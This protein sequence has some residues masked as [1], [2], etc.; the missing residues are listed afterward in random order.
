MFGLHHYNVI[1]IMLHVHACML[2][3]VWYFCVVA[4]SSVVNLQIINMWKYRQ[5]TF[6]FVPLIQG[7][8]IGFYAW[9]LVW[10]IYLIASSPCCTWKPL[11]DNTQHP[12]LQHRNSILKINL[13]NDFNM[14]ITG[15][16]SN[17]TLLLYKL[18]KWDVYQV[19]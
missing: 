19:L 12:K 13:G 5:S 10:C 11:K 14:F 2:L 16:I 17:V 6:V 1:N 4:R 3:C 18:Y 9:T 15:E 7:I 8:Q